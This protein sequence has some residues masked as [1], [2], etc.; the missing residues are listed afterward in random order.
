VKDET[1]ET[2][3][4]VAVGGLE[5]SLKTSGGIPLY[6]QMRELLRE[7]IRQGDWSPD[8]PMPTE[9]VLGAHFGVSRNTVRQAL[10]D[11][12]REGLITR[13]A[14]KGS[15][16]RQPRMV[17]KMEHFY[18]LSADLRER[19]VR[20][21]RQLLEVRCLTSSRELAH[22][23]A[24]MAEGPVIRIHEVR[25][26]NERPVV[27][28]EYYYPADLCGFLLDAPLDDPQLSLTDLMTS[29]G[30][31]FARATGEIN[32]ATVT[33]EEARLLELPQGAPVVEITS[34][35]YN[36]SGRV[37]EYARSVIRTDRYPL[38]LDSDW[39]V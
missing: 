18:S 28:F 1:G 31:D 38:E 20:P 3:G 37:V 5:S 27:V 25:L 23:V 30:V 15:F 39:A 34:R 26:A 17:L 12:V 35:T 10:A 22:H 16:V 19:G 11:L 6:V 29:H 4:L 7:R 2:N 36:R 21:S 33:D 24:E 32:A 9:E 14:G 13:R 8:E